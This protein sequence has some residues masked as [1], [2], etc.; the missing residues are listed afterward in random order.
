MNQGKH[1]PVQG[2]GYGLCLGWF[3]FAPNAF[4]NPA[5]TSYGGPLKSYI[6]SVTYSATGV[7]T[8]VFKTGFSFAQ[9]PEFMPVGVAESLSEHYL[10]Q[11][12]AA[13]NTSTRT[14]VLQQHRN[15]AG[16]EVPA[17]AATKIVVFVFA[18]DT[19][20]K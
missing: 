6:S 16:R 4:N 2:L 20:G 13:Y 17:N 19:Q 5:S 18:Q 7:Q 8:V 14:L 10:V 3:S 9:T 11:Q 15:G 1:G 12:T